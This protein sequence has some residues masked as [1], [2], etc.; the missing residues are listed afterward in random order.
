MNTEQPIRSEIILHEDGNFYRRDVR[1]V[2]IANADLVVE[3]S[4]R[5]D[6][7]DH[8]LFPHKTKG[9]N[10]TKFT[11][12]T[13]KIV[14]SG[15]PSPDF[16]T[17]VFVKLQNGFPYPKARK[18]DGDRAFFLPNP[19]NSEGHFDFDCL[20][21]HPTEYD[22]YVCLK[23]IIIE[24][25]S[26]DIRT[27]TPTAYLF[28]VHHKTYDVVTFNLPNIYDNGIICTGPDWSASGAS[29]DQIADYVTELMSTF[30]EAPFNLDLRH[31]PLESAFVGF[32]QEGR[33][34][35]EKA[36]KDAFFTRFADE[37]EAEKAYAT[38][39][40]DFFPEISHELL[41]SYAQCLK[42]KKI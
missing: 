13:Q 41:T 26:N 33:Q 34:V 8:S 12:T 37:A 40:K 20:Y 6:P 19:Q 2:A 42:S 3:Q 4:L 15:F 22:M 16:I 32:N 18:P 27:T 29:A 30:Y 1:E 31:P 24:R 28:G 5:K 17:H 9:T 23:D 25:S 36:I 39:K 11:I 35:N 7:Y 38:C 21:W 14:T 10:A